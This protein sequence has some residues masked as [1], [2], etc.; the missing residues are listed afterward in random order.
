MAAR[1]RQ[2][3]LARAQRATE[4]EARPYNLLTEVGWS[5][6][7]ERRG[8]TVGR[9]PPDRCNVMT[10][11]SIDFFGVL[12]GTCPRYNYCSRT[13]LTGETNARPSTIPR[14]H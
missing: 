10:S 7:A 14:P 6:L 8:G 9:T 11:G 12:H 13:G 4:A 2:R 1:V 5:Q 3:G